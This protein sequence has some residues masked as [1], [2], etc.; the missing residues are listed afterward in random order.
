MLAMPVMLIGENHMFDIADVLGREGALDQTLA[1]P[2]IPGGT[3][4]IINIA[5]VS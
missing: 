5:D 3:D 2:V 4:R 1:M